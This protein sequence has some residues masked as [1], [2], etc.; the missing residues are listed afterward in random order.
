VRGPVTVHRRDNVCA[1]VLVCP[2]AGEDTVTASLY[3]D[4]HG[5]S[6]ASAL[7]GTE[8]EGAPGAR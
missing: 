3:L 7:L 4:A 2:R 1:L 5:K 8:L 6:L